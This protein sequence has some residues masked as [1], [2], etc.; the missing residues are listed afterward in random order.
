MNIDTFFD[1]VFYINMDKDVDR[2]DAMIAQFNKFGITNYERVAAT[3]INEVPEKYLWRN[4]NVNRLNEKYILGSIGCMNSHWRIMQI[5]LE[6]RYQKIMILEDD[7]V[8]LQDPNTVLNQS[9]NELIEW[10]M[11]YFGGIEEHHFG[12]QIVCA[13]AYGM[14]RKLI[15][16][17]YHMLP[18]SGMEVDNFYAKI[19][20]HMSY[21]YRPG[22]KY[23][24][25]KIHPF[26]TIIQN[27]LYQSNIQS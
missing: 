19:L 2:N 24:I 5:A 12:G 27:K 23:L 11:L 20:F 9:E 10:D 25:K 1:K 7:V 21:N 17:T 15:E 26:N 3:Q 16:E 22:G 14:N 6:R 13:H 8:F 18:A 4:F